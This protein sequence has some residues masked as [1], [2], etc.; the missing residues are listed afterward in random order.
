M[1]KEI[2]LS[3][4]HIWMDIS[5]EHFYTSALATAKFLHGQQPGCTAYVIGEPG[6]VNAL[7]EAGITMNDVNPDYVVVGET[8]NYN[9]D[10]ILSAVKFVRGGAKLIGTN[11]D[12]TGPVSYTHLSFLSIASIIKSICGFLASFLPSL[13]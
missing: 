1:N 6:L 10:S 3:L 8:H 13:P 5:E 9:Y 2:E 11:P 7:Y 12:M 4:I